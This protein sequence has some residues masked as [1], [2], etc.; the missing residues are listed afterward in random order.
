MSTSVLSP[1]VT[2]HP[3]RRWWLRAIVFASLCAFPMISR[4]DWYKK[5]IF[6]AGMAAWI[7][8]YPV[9]SVRCEHFEKGMFIMFV[10]ARRK[11]WSLDRFIR[12]ETGCEPEDEAAGAW[13]LFFGEWYIAWIVMDWIIPWVG[14]PMKLWLRSKSGNRVLAWQGQS[15]RQF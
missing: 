3:V 4:A 9:A 6:A 10:P 11:R 14:G 12:I 7:G 8:S 2:L 5:L 13:W 15:D 1:L